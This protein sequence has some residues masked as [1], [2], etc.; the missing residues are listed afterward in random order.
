MD[1]IVTPPMEDPSDPIESSQLGS[2]NR[3]D[4]IEVGLTGS[5]PLDF[6]RFSTPTAF[7]GPPAQPLAESRKRRRQEMPRNNKL[8]EIIHDAVKEAMSGH[9]NRLDAGFETHTGRILRLMTEITEPLIAKV[10]ECH[11]DRLEGT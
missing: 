3:M 10:A 11:G 6:S 4:G 2:Q 8:A 1:P 7:D 5:N 9:L